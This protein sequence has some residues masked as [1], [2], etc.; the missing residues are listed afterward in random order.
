MCARLLTATVWCLLSFVSL[1]FGCTCGGP[2]LGSDK[3]SVRDLV[4]AQ[5]SGNDEGQTVFEGTVELQD[6]SA[7]PISAPKSAM[8]MTPSGA[9]RIVT[10]RAARVYR[11]VMEQNFTIV[12]GMGYGDCGFD[13]RTGQSYL[14][15]ATQIE[16]GVYFT[17]ICSGTDLLE[18]SGPA[19][20][21]LRGEPPT[22]DD[23]LDVTSYYDQMR[24][25]WTGGVCGSVIGPDGKAVKSA[26]VNLSEIRDAPY[27]QGGGAE[28]S[29]ADGS[30]CIKNIPPGKYLL[31][32][33]KY[34]FE[35][36]TRLMG[37]YPDG[38][39]HSDAEQIDL[40]ARSTIDAKP[41]KMHREELFDIKIKVVTSDGSPPPW[42]RI[43][44]A[45][46]SAER[47]PL[48][49]NIDHG[50]DENG[51]YEFGYIPAG[52]YTV[53]SFV[54]PD[55]DA[56][57]SERAGPINWTQDRREIDVTGDTEVVLKITPKN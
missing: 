4:T 50:V 13:F 15:V 34:D 1:G 7:G 42:K 26:S 6:I 23:L 36:W 18:R 44:V 11:G 47:D 40:K 28:L 46:Q 45:V 29:A 17:S 3:N 31:T 22:V 8:S 41:L 16:S 51:S 49:Y 27:P 19:V 20:R 30:Y 38:L 52:H 37:F 55:F 2:H 9:H 48:A 12:T 43:G 32:A 14:V 54:Q 25:Q 10:I 5:F 24:P 39:K 56:P 33:E 57:E 21:F 53:I 35:N